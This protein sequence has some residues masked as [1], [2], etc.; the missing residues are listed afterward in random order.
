MS[1]K[2]YIDIR[3]SDLIRLRRNLDKEIEAHESLQDQMEDLASTDEG[4]LQAEHAER[5]KHEAVHTEVLE[6]LSALHARKELWSTGMDLHADLEALHAMKE[7]GKAHFL[8]AFADFR[9]SVRELG[10]QCRDHQDDEDISA[11]VKALREAVTNINLEVEHALSEAPPT[12]P[13]TTPS[14]PPA[15]PTHSHATLRIDLPTFDGSP[16]NWEQFETLFLSTAR[17]RAKGFSPMELRGLLRNAV[18]PDR[19]RR[20]LDN[21]PSTSTSLEEMLGELKT[22]Y[23]SPAVVGPIIVQKILS[24]P[25]LDF[26]Y[27]S[28][29]SF[30]DNFCLPWKRFCSST[31]GSLSSFLAILAVSRM[32]DNCRDEWLRTTD[33]NKV[34]QMEEVNAF[35]KKWMTR[36]PSSSNRH[37][38]QSPS[39]PPVHLSSN[40]SNAHHSKPS[41]PRSDHHH[42]PSKKFLVTCHACGQQHGLVRCESFRGP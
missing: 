8:K 25:K 26:D 5:E 10:R 42:S 22:L 11:L 20:I 27:Q 31:D 6:T 2:R 34:P 1:E 23:G 33:S 32:N 19:A 3:L 35:V 7:P 40:P 13:T 28:L 36:F 9:T 37:P 24:S 30:H 18:K 12:T 41:H 17:T 15:E 4:I 16:E 21:L 14:S 39:N 29:S 38:T